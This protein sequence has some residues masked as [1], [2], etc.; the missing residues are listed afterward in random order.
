MLLMTTAMKQ[1]P[2]NP[3]LLTGY[4]SP[5]YF[6]DREE[7]TRRL[8]SALRNGR[9]VT[10]ISPRRM[11]KTGLIHHAFHL[12][13][14]NDEHV[15]C[16]YVDLYQ[17][18][19]LA[20]LVKQLANV[21]LGTLDTRET[22]VVKTVAAFFKSLRPTLSLDPMSGEPTF[23][24]DLQPQMAE[25]SLAEIFQYMEQSGRQCYIAFDEFQSIENYGEKNIEALLRSYVQRLASVHFIFSGSQRHLLEEMFASVARP[26]FQSTQMMPLKEITENAYYTF[27]ENKFKAHAQQL[28]EDCFHTIYSLLHGHTWYVQMVLNRLYEDHWPVITLEIISQ[29]IQIITQENEATYQTFMR[30][31]TPFQGRLLRAI[32]CEGSVKEVLGKNFLMKYNLGAASTVRS[33][34]KSLVDKELVLDQNDVYEVYDRFFGIWLSRG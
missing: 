27:A 22:K 3:F 17:T 14:R 6:C 4:I 29:T 5:E 15:S 30:L 16:Y 10:L 34:I 33:S 26:F 11:G 21:V 13:E 9:N 2:T 25:H 32:A 23:S 8:T 1:Q 7:E 19:S 31:I 24:V 18:D 20:S 12:M 28:T